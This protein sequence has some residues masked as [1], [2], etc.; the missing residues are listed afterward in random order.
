[1]TTTLADV[2]RRKHAKHLIE[3]SGNVSHVECDVALFALMV[4]LNE[5]EEAWRDEYASLEQQLASS[6]DA[7]MAQRQEL[8]RRQETIDTLRAGLA[9]ATIG[10]DAL[11]GE[12]A[13]LIDKINRMNESSSPTGAPM[14]LF[15]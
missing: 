6:C 3:F 7:Q 12:C 8:A 9:Q 13:R 1:M 15:A 5:L 2:V 11:E 10:N 14:A 4:A